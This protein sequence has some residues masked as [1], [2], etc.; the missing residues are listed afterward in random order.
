MQ[1]QQGRIYIG[2]TPKDV[3]LVLYCGRYAAASFV[4]GSN[5]DEALLRAPVGSGA[6]TTA[7]HCGCE[8]WRL[9]GSHSRPRAARPLPCSSQGPG[10][11]GLGRAGPVGGGAA[12]A[13]AGPGQ[14][15]RNSEPCG[16][17]GVVAVRGL[18]GLTG[19]AAGRGSTRRGRSDRGPPAAP[20]AAAASSSM[21]SS[22][23]LY[24][25]SATWGVMVKGAIHLPKSMSAG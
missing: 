18:R 4:G 20:R 14:A 23:P 7:L 11:V 1:L 22:Q 2:A 8:S 9:N 17:V 3:S 15:A 13:V 6:C 21:S 25:A 24:F 12:A 19:G 16:A 10:G 5:V